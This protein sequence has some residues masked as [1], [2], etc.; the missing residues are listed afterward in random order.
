MRAVARLFNDQDAD[1][2]GKI[3]GMYAVLVIANVLA[4][5][6]ALVA[7]HDYPVLLGTAFLAYTFGLRH[8]VDA[9]HIAAIDNVTRKLMQEGKRPVG[10]GFF[11][12]LGHSTVVVLAIRRRSRSPPA[13]LEGRFESFKV[14]GGTD[15]HAGVGAVSCSPSRPSTSLILDVGLS[16]VPARCAAAARSSR[17][18]STVCWRSAACSAALF[19]PLFR[20]VARSWHMYPL[21]LLFGLGFDTATEIGLLGISAAEASQ[22]LADLVDP[23]VPGAVHRRHVADRHHRRHPD[24][25]RLWLGL[26]QA[27]PQALLQSDHHVRFGAGRRADRRHRGARPDRRQAQPRRAVLALRSAR[28]TTISAASA[29]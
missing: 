29:I 6:W 23:G 17:R 16:H 4:W 13:A 26:R 22:G 12:S 15:R 3:A 21:G 8:A 19:R 27:D 25:R 18:T 14:V 11:F 24:A 10:V 28:S 9:D 2:A 5:M 20:L 1:L 7:F